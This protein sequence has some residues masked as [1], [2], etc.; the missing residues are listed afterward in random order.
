MFRKSLI[1]YLV[2][3]SQN[4]LASDLERTA[5]QNLE[6]IAEHVI[7]TNQE[8]PKILSQYRFLDTDSLRIQKVT[9]DQNFIHPTTQKPSIDNILIG[10]F[11]R[12][13]NL[14][15]SARF[16]PSYLYGKEFSDGDIGYFF[17]G[18][19]YELILDKKVKKLYNDRYLTNEFTEPTL[20][21]EV[22]VDSTSVN[23]SSVHIS[24]SEHPGLVG[25]IVDMVIG[26]GGVP[27]DIYLVE[28][29]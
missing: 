6:I 25:Q 2:F 21:L 3:F 9:Y 5:H 16:R 15:L 29:K 4:L 28:F 1:L 10:F 22:D 23:R 17:S 8:I 20:N 13:E 11:D 26:S 7:P 12:F 14:L 19:A 24:V 27:K 18:S